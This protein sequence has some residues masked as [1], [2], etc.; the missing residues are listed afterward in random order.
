ME[1]DDGDG[2]RPNMASS[3]L[4]VHVVVLWEGDVVHTALL[5][6]GQSFVLGDARGGW[7]CPASALRG[8]RSHVLVRVEQRGARFTPPGGGATWIACGQQASA[9]LEGIRVLA[10]AGVVDGQVQSLR[11]R[12]WD[13]R[14]GA[15][16][17]LTV[18]AHA[19]LLVLAAL[20]PPPLAATAQV[21]PDPELPLRPLTA[22]ASFA[23]FELEVPEPEV[24]LEPSERLTSI[25]GWARCGGELEMGT[26]TLLAGGRFGNA[27]PPDNADP[28]LAAENG[29]ARPALEVLAHLPPA[30]P[31]PSDPR[32]ELHRDPYA[33]TALWGRETP[34]GTDPESARAQLLG[35]MLG[36][37]SGDGLNGKRRAPGGKAKQLRVRAAPPD[38]RRLPPRVVHTGL[39]VSGSLDSARVAHSMLSSLPA[40]RTCYAN[41]LTDTSQA[42]RLEL[43]FTI[44]PGGSVTDRSATYGD[45][46]ASDLVSCM[47][48]ATK[49]L[50]FDQ[51]PAH[52][53]VTYPLLLIP[54]APIT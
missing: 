2:V 11:T 29:P 7:A 14:L 18:L 33:L 4:R 50:R 20:S 36:E 21:E 45:S 24:A 40:F 37:S 27:G 49:T 16:S 19:A 8:A 51:A 17:A 23:E 31:H 32:P 47:L 41:S 44:A 39:R 9:Q 26:P 43:T 35:D 42:D 10:S 1:P 28:H 12:R 30:R 13:T 48:H 22:V 46:V 52:T 15:S 5:A 6:P 34:L 38:L 25:D 53:T 54:P 3:E